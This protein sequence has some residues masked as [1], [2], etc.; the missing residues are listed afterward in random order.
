MTEYI[1]QDQAVALAVAANVGRA[2][3]PI[4]LDTGDVIYCDGSYRTHE[5]TALCNAAIQHYIQ[6]LEPV[7]GDPRA[8]VVQGCNRIYTGAFAAADAKEDAR[9]I[10]GTCYAYPL[11]THPV[12]ELSDGEKR[13][14]TQAIKVTL[15]LGGSPV[16]LPSD[17]WI[18]KALIAA[19]DVI[20]KARNL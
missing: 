20:K 14:G 6:S 12:R 10:G 11:Y 13:I 2:I 3:K 16:S 19:L 17:F 4:G 1:T 18:E 9:R 7:K 8:W 15:M 5:I